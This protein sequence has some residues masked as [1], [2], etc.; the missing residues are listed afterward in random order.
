MKSDKLYYTALGFALG[1]LISMVVV[2][3][4]PSPQPDFVCAGCGSLNW[5]SIPAKED[6]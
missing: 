5:H 3:W 1:V 6:N 2:T 4:M